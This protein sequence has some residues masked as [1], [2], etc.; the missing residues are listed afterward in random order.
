MTI[1]FLKVRATF[2]ILFFV[3]PS[4]Y[5]S[6]P[7]WFWDFLL[8]EPSWYFLVYFWLSSMILMS[9]RSVSSTW[10][11]KFCPLKNI[12]GG[13]LSIVAR[14]AM[15][16]CSKCIGNLNKS[17]SDASDPVG[18]NRWLL[19]R[20]VWVE[21]GHTASIEHALFLLRSPFFQNCSLNLFCLFVLIDETINSHQLIVWAKIVK[22]SSKTSTDPK[23]SEFFHITIYHLFIKYLLGA[24]YRCCCYVQHLTI[25]VSKR[26]HLR[27]GRSCALVTGGKERS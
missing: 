20:D 13:Q 23:F 9:C 22:L 24:C 5:T 15:K 18:S 6:F 3:L 10:I 25:K 14:I 16:V 1:W 7:C 8:R 21:L 19:L 17:V 12:L 26:L 11:F 27:V 4:L 2:I